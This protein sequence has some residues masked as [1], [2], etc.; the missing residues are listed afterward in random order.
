MNKGHNVVKTEKNI[1]FLFVSFSFA[2]LTLKKSRHFINLFA[3][4]TQI[5]LSTSFTFF[6]L[7]VQSLCMFRP[8]YLGHLEGVT[9]LIDVYNDYGNMSQMTSKFYTHIRV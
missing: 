2:Y 3:A 4:C 8:I 9:I 6:I 1:H 7:T 5:T